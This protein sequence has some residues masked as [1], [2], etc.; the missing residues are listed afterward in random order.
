MVHEIKILARWITELGP[1]VKSTGKAGSLYQVIVPAESQ[2][3]EIRPGSLRAVDCLRSLFDGP[4]E[5][6]SLL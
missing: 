1:D 3:G 5:M 2:T 4:N 6:P